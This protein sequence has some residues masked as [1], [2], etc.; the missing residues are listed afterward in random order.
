MHCSISGA[1]WASSGGPKPRQRARGSLTAAQGLTDQEPQS[2]S[3]IAKAAGVSTAEAGSVLQA[4]VKGGEVE[5]GRERGTY[6]LLIK[7]GRKSRKAA[8]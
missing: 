8:R 1:E 6:L 7:P 5:K 2:M 3:A 4:G